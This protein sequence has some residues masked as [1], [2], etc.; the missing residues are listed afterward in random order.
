MYRVTPVG[1]T[2]SPT[3][4]PSASPTTPSPSPT[5]PS[6]SPTTP[7][8]SPTGGTGIACH[9]TYSKQS[10]W[11][12][13]FTANVTVANSGSATV[14]GWTLAFSFPGDQKVTSAWNATV[15]QTGQNVTA[16][17][18]SYNSV[19]SPGGNTSFGFQGTWT[20]SDTSP[21]AFTLNGTTC[22]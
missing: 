17:N 19:I 9:V 22:S 12:G 16:K 7:S 1:V 13:G 5:T 14:N 4:T 11:A 8:P 10:E 6:P 3:P 15:T 2:H 18:L 20:A 21:S